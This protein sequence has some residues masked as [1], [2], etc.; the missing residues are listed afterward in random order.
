MVLESEKMFPRLKLSLKRLWQEAIIVLVPGWDKSGGLCQERR[1]KMMY[2]VKSF[3]YQN[4]ECDVQLWRSLTKEVPK[5]IACLVYKKFLKKQKKVA[6]CDS[7]VMSM[8]QPFGGST[9]Y[10]LVVLQP[11][12]CEMPGWLVVCVYL[13]VSWSSSTVKP[14]TASPSTPRCQ[15]WRILGKSM[16]VLPSP[17]LETGNIFSYSDAAMER[18]SPLHHL[19]THPFSDP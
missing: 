11:F 10:V 16:M 9:V 19:S 1:V 14:E 6:S 7:F 12:S 3:P 4:A 18:W 13:S 8:L 15:A 17:S 5:E 2:N